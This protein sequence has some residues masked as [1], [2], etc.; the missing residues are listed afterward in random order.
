MNS[1][2]WLIKYLAVRWPI[3]IL[4]LITGD[5][6]V[7]GIH[8]PKLFFAIAY[9]YLDQFVSNA[10]I[11][12]L[13]IVYNNIF[14]QLCDNMQVFSQPIK[15]LSIEFSDIGIETLKIDAGL[16]VKWNNEMRGERD[17]PKYLKMPITKL[18]TS[19]EPYWL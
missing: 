17:G 14:I 4:C 16:L 18:I 7:V 6:S 5:N 1:V 15:S 11:I 10:L 19:H 13:A 3:F 8:P 9:A 2:I 12:F